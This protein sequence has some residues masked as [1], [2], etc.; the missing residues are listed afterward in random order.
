MELF[1]IGFILGLVL[2]LIDGVI[3]LYLYFKRKYDVSFLLE[4]ADD[5]LVGQD[6][7]H[8]NR[9]VRRKSY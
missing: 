8:S 5:E 1:I 7:G 6:N 9:K 4:F 2:T 3:L